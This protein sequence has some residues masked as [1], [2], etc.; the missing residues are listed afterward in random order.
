MEKE[1]TKAEEEIMHVFWKIGKGF[2]KDVLEE[3]P[4][5]KPA[6]NTV[7]TIVRIMVQKGFLGYEAFGKTHR[8]HPLIAKEEYTQSHLSQFIRGYFGNSYKRLV[9]FLVKEENLTVEEMDALLKDIK[10]EKKRA[11][12]NKKKK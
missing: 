5:P 2:V 12:R 9:S 7:S 10:A 3:L 8:Y 4:E 1:L 11:P 6:Y